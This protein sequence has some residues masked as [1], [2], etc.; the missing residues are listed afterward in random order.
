[1]NTDYISH[2]TYILLIGMKRWENKKEKE[3]K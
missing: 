1:M 3:E 2:N